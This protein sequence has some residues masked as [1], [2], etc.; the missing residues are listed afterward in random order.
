MISGSADESALASVGP[1]VTRS[2]YDL[3]G[4]H[5]EERSQCVRVIFAK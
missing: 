4:R 3:E 5:R 2:S 1:S